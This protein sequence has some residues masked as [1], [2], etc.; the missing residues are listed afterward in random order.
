MNKTRKYILY[1]AAAVLTAGCTTDLPDPGRTAALIP[2][3]ISVGDDGVIT[4]AGIEVQEAQFQSGETFYV[5][6]ADGSAVNRQNNAL[7]S[8]KF[9]TTDANGTATPAVGSDSAYFNPEASSATLHAYYPQTVNETTTSFEVAADQTTDA[10][11]KAS[12]LMYAT[13]TA[14]KKGTKVTIPLKFE[15]RMAKITVLAMA[16]DNVT[17]IRAIRIISGYRKVNIADPVTATPGTSLSNALS[18]TSPLLMYSHGGDGEEVIFT[19]AVLPPQTVEGSFLEFDT[20]DG[21][22]TYPIRETKLE[23]GHAYMLALR[24]GAVQGSGDSG[25]GGLGNSGHVLTVAPIDDQEYTGREITPDVVVREGDHV[26]TNV[27]DDPDGPYYKV[28]YSNATEVGCAQV[29]V[30]GLR[31]YAGCV[32]TSHFNIVQA[33]GTI[34]FDEAAVE[35]TYWP[36]A[37]YNGNTLDIFGD[38][39]SLTYSTEDTDV[40]SVDAETGVVTLKDPGTAPRTATVTATIT[41]GRNYHFATPTAAYTITVYPRSGIGLGYD[42][43]NWGGDSG[44]NGTVE[45]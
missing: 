6:F 11:Y 32:S 37:T 30:V 39:G 42:I 5:R 28:V 38:Y 2:I 40:I 7:A 19:A 10:A 9:T 8:T 43:D 23:G 20:D 25:T 35:V 15:H 41:D 16:V 27:P 33:A 45:F 21:T 31:D 12:D 29:I 26:L 36:G 44:T 18:T 34:D 17:K 24:V 3:G 4:R 1:S 13:T 22:Y 14:L